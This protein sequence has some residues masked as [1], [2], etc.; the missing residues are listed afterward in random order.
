MM[1]P[2]DDSF[3]SDEEEE[4]CPL[5]V[6]EMD[7][8]DKNFKPCPCGYQ[9]CQ[10][11]YNNIRQNPELN[12]RCP[13][14][15]RL[16]DDDSVEYKTITSDEY[17]MQQLKREKREREKKQREK[18]KKET[19]MANKKHLAGLRVVQK[20]LVYVTGL[21]PPC[22]PDDLHS[23]L[24]SDKYF[25]QYG[26]ILKIVINKKTPNP[27]SAH[28]H[29]QNPGLVVY[30]TFV[31]KED[32][33]KCINELD[34]SLC[35]GRVL[36]AAH[37]TTKYCSSYLRGHPCPNPNC[38]FLHEPGE[39]ADSY[40]RKDLSTQQGIKMGMM[41]LSG[42][43]VEG[44]TNITNAGFNNQNTSSNNSQHSNS[45]EEDNDG[46]D[47][48]SD[49]HTSSPNPMPNSVSSSNGAVLPATAH[50]AK[51]LSSASGSP[52]VNSTALA[53]AAAFPTL[54][55]IFRD[56]KQ[57][58]R[59][60]GKINKGKVGRSSKDNSILLP[61]DIDIDND[62]AIHFMEETSE[63][64][65]NLSERREK[66]QVYFKKLTENADNKVLPLFAFN[67]STKLSNN[68][69]LEEEKLIARQVIE[70]FILKPIKNY[71][72]AY[73]NHP[74]TQQQTLLQQQAQLQQQRQQTPSIQA[75]QIQ[76]LQI[77]QQKR[78]LEQQSQQTGNGTPVSTNAPLQQQQQLL[79]LQ[80]LQQQQQQQQQH[81]P[82]QAQA[83][84]NMI[85]ARERSANTS[86]PPPPGLFA[87]A[88]GSKSTPN[89]PQ[90]PAQPQ[91]QPQGQQY[92][93]QPAAGNQSSSS[94][95]LTQLMSGKR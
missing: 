45:A 15:R 87:A 20:N 13:G 29:H 40:T 68:S 81:T 53:N 82:S 9:I 5:C 55:E 36:R 71:H 67:K 65:R 3:I 70:R 24:R 35:D 39:E 33:L 73:Q 83:Q 46:S 42:S 75:A 34:G 19:E 56:Q 4:F 17:R 21:N 52:S 22:N 2:S 90:M 61:D 66:L 8:S 16:Y 32:A 91:Q 74:I 43:S 60:E 37:G 25:G 88:N 79:L 89:P 44:N 64:L 23:V 95:L 47:D 14:C 59:K 1:V 54:G 38:M 49:H 76:Q 7:I 51:G 27:Q 26:K 10:F 58:Q 50:W 94:Q 57:Q 41:G 63:M 11:C 62:S 30:V 48:D 80:Q 93:Q 86:T 6:E 78:L 69:N 28:H 18:E 84:I 31:K 77:E 92:A 72:L 85:R 12:G